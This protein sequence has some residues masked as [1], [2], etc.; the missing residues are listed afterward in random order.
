[1]R[2]G[3]CG[4]EGARKR[5]FATM[6]KNGNKALGDAK[7][8]KKDEFYTQLS[9]INNE[10]RHYTQHFAG[11]VVFCNCD[12]PYES[13]FFKYFAANFNALKLKRLVATCYA[14]SPVAGRQLDLFEDLDFHERVPPGE[15]RAP[16]R[17]KIP[18]KIVIN[19]VTDVNGDGRIDLADVE[20]LIK[21]DKNVLT[22]LEGDGDFRSAECIELLKQSDIVVTNPPFSLFREYVAQ[23]IQYGK[24]F[25]II[26]NV[27]SV[28]CK[29]IFPL[30]KDNK[31]WLGV[32]IHSGDRKFTVPQDYPL[33]AAGC[34]IDE[35]GQ[36]YIRVKGVRWYTNLDHKK[37]H[38]EY[39]FVRR[40]N[41]V[42]YP[43]LDNFDAILVEESVDVPE[44][45]DG[46]LA[47]PST[48][49]DRYNPDQFEILGITKTW[50]GGAT[51][52]YPKQIQVDANGNRSNVSKLNDGAV[53]R[54]ETPP[55]GKTYYLVDGVPYVQR[56]PRI[57]IR[58]KK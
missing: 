12:D 26:G 32:S 56:Y 4:G 53:I 39:V 18:H 7:K 58:R 9:D 50:D 51:K 45:F 48:F 11:K 44:D 43:R 15:G 38:E 54:V 2:D 42:D 35:D 3:L 55:K 19:E 27:N 36:R 29:E 21:N 37:R 8:Q 47:V 34:G 24:K 30:I 10:L 46:C 16:A 25:L 40:Y 22:R 31:M 17:P 49:L 13:N 1:M 52:K 57:I 5:R 41:P 6:A 28:T 33:D 14:G 23:L 20:W